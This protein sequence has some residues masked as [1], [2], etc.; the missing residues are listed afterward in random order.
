MPLPVGDDPLVEPFAMGIMKPFPF[1]N[2]FE[3]LALSNMRDDGPA[4]VVEL[5]ETERPDD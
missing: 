3:R 2:P 5:M 1:V 4:S